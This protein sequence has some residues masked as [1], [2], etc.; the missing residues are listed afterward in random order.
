MFSPKY[1]ITNKLLANIRRLDELIMRLNNRRFPNVIMAE[2]KKSAQAVSAHASTSIEGN[3]LPLTEV[4][5]ILKS[6]PAHIRDT[7]REVLNYNKVLLSLDKQ[8]N[9]SLDL[10]LNIQRQVTAGL[11]AQGDWGKFRNRPVVVNNPR[12]GQIAYIPPAE[13]DV[14]ELMTNFQTLIPLVSAN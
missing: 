4:K 3:P 10:I 12:T 9:F 14:E 8:A 2:F 1:T 7:E 5:M 11:I 13:S 6:R